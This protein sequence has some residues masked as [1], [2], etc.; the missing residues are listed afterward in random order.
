[1]PNDNLYFVTM[2]ACEKI[3]EARKAAA[4][5]RLV[6]IADDARR[7]NHQ[8]AGSQRTGAGLLR[9]LAAPFRHGRPVL[10]TTVAARRAQ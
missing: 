5:D 1:M 3:A 2:I 4:H 6:L 7:E 9:S 10:K 8:A